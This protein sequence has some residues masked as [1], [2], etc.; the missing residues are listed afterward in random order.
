[1]S[2]TVDALL[3]LSLLQAVRRID[4][5]D[6]DEEAEYVSELRNKR[7]GLSDT[8]FAQIRRY[9]DAVK[10]GLRTGADETVALA[11]LIGRRP[12]AESVFREAGRTLA[13]EAYGTIPTTTRRMMR[14]LPRFLARPIALRRIDRAAQRYLNGRVR[15]VGSALILDVPEPLTADAAPNGK[16]CAFYESCLRELIALTTAG[17]PAL[18][19]IRCTARGEGACEWKAEWR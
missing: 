2:T 14:V 6:D 12:D 8:V 11:R 3:P 1:M 17:G 19:H 16:G 7:L 18:E 13:A 4:T 5:P 15:R 9:A 10:R